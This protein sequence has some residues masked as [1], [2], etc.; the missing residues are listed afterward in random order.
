MKST[1]V[2]YGEN[3]EEEKAA[4]IW[5]GGRFE[6]RERQI[7]PWLWPLQSVYKSAKRK[8]RTSAAA[9]LRACA[10][11]GWWGAAKLHLHKLVPHDLCRCGK[12]ADTLWH[13]LGRRGRTEEARSST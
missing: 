5:R 4:R 3:E 13:K 11:G 10:E 8:G 6:Q 2:Y 1:T 9:S 12:A 7:V